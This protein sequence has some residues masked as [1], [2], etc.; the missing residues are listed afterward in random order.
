VDLE[1]G[2][3]QQFHTLFVCPVTKDTGTP[4]NPP[5]LLV[6]GHVISA[7][8]LHKLP[9]R[10]GGRYVVVSPG[11]SEA[12]VSFQNQNTSDLNVP[13]AQL[14]KSL[15]KRGKYIFNPA[16]LEAQDKLI[17]LRCTKSYTYR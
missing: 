5:M 13:T 1:L 16:T 2:N 6:C 8:A 4:S 9:T 17:S 7:L 12:Q 11:F 10:A 14:N 15:R 3:T